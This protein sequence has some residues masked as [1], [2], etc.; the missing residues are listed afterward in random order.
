MK[1]R[2]AFERHIKSLPSYQKQLFIHGERLFIMENGQYKIAAVHLAWELYQQQQKVIDA[3]IKH[4]ND[5]RDLGKDHSA[6]LA[7]K[8]LRGDS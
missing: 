7:L 8:A 4:L 2:Q 6:Y 5:V 3:A 1:V